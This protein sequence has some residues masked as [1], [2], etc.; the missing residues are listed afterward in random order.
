MPSVALLICL[1]R[2]NKNILCNSPFSKLHCSY[3]QVAV[4]T[5][6]GLLT[7]SFVTSKFSFFWI[8]ALIIMNFSRL[9]AV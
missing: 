8:Y 9:D 1:G 3:I 6:L 5:L 4:A 2:I 7:I